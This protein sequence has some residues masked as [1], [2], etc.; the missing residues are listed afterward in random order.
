MGILQK[1]RPEQQ[2]AQV[3]PAYAVRSVFLTIRISVRSS[4][5]AALFAGA[6]HESQSK[7]RGACFLLWPMA[8]GDKA[9]NRAVTAGYASK[10]R[11]YIQVKV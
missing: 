5:P 7:R 8:N 1:N 10:S 11:S 9:R 4:A 3:Y 2:I 6:D